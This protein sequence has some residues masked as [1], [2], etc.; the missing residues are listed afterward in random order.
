MRKIISIS[1]LALLCSLSLWANETPV[2]S[3]DSVSVDTV[4]NPDP[5]WYVA[6]LTRDSLR[7]GKRALVAATSCAI[8]SVHIFNEDS[9]LTGVTVYEYGDTTRTLTWTINSDGSRVGLSKE[10]SGTNGDITFSASYEWDATANNWKGTAKEEHTFAG[11]K[12]TVRTSYDWQNGAW[13]AKTQYTWGYDASGRE[14]EYTTYVRNTAGSLVYSKQRLREY[15]AAGRMVQEIQ[16]TAHNGTA[17]SAG[18]KRIYDYDG[19]NI[20]LNEYYSTYT[21]GTWVGSSKEI[22]T[23]TAGKKTYYEK[24]TWSNGAWVG[25]S[26]EIWVFNGPSSKQ[27]LHETYSWTNGDWAVTA[28]ENSGYDANGNNTLIENYT[29]TNGVQKGSKK[30]ENTFSGSTKVETVTYKWTNDAWVKNVK[31]VNN[32]VSSPAESCRYSWNG[33]EW[34]GSGNRTLTTNNSS[35]KP[36]EVITQTWSSETNSWV[37]YTRATT[38]YTGSKTTQEATY[39]WQNDAWVGTSRSDWHYNAKG[40]ND[41]IKTYTNNGTEWIYSD[42]TAKTYNA[43]GTEI[44][45]HKAQWNGEKWVMTSMTRTDILDHTID[46]VRQTLNASWRC[47][48][49]SVWIG[50]Q[51]DTAVFSATGKQIYA[52]K[53]TSWANNDW[54][55]SYKQTLVYDEADRLLLNERYNWSAN[56]WKGSFRYEYGYDEQGRQTYSATYN[57]WSSTTN[58]WVGTTMTETVFNEMGQTAEKKLYNWNN[59]WTAFNR[60]LYTYDAEGHLIDQIVQSNSNNGW[61]NALRYEKGYHNNILVVSNDYTWINNAWCITSKNEKTYDEDSDA[62][63]RR[64]IIGKWNNSTGAAISFADNR[65]FYDCDQHLYT[66]RFLNENGAILESKQVQNGTMPAFSGE[67]PTKEA[68]AENTYTFTGW[69]KAIAEVSGDATYTAVFSATKRQYTITWLNEDGTEI[70]HETLEYGLTPAH[71]D[72]YKESTAEYTYTFTGWDKEITPVIG[73]A[74]YKAVFSATKRQYTI[75]WLNE[76]GTEIDHE[77][78]E[79]GLTPAHADIYKE[80]TAEYTYTFTGWDKEITPVIGDA[81]YKAAFTTTKRQY[82]IIWLNEDGSELD[83]Q[84]L[85]YGAMPQHADATK[86]STAE[87]TYTFAGWGKEIASVT[88]NE[89]YQATFTATK[90]QYTITWLNEDNS[91]LAQ[92][93]VEYGVMPTAPETPSKESTAEYTYTFVGWDAEPASVTGNAAYTAVFTATKRQYTITWLS[94]DGSMI[95]QTTVEYGAMPQHADPSKESTAEYT[96]TF[97]GWDAEP[98]SVT[99]DATYKATFTATKRQYTITWLSDDG[100]MIDQTTVEYGAM[101]QHADPS[102]EPTAEYTYTFVGWDSDP[103]PVTGAAIYKAVYS[104]NKNS[105]TVTFYFEDGVT[106]LDSQTLEYGETPT[107]TMTPS[108]NAEEHYYYTFIGWSPEITPV[109]GDASYTPVFTKEPKQYTITFNNYNGRQLWTTTVPYGETPEYNGETPTRLRTQQYT[110]TFAGWSPEL[111]AVSGNATYTALFDAIVNQ[112][113]VVFQNEDGTEL[114]RQ[115]VDYGTKPEYQGETPTKEPDE[116]YRYEFAGWTP[117]IAAV[118]GDATYTATYTRHDL[119]EGI[120]NVQSP[121]MEA[122]KVLRNGTFYILRG[123]KTYTLDGVLVE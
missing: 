36:V 122:Q 95:D 29:Y 109:T 79:Y 69:D 94:D 111:T 117:R 55:P 48:A 116:N 98:A 84:T 27:T 108:K 26:K 38:E 93:T 101:P 82:T 65:Y 67:T 73:D 115:L 44:M 2:S 12:E 54:I 49:D 62:K 59:G 118:Y 89:T 76:D 56:K 5:E 75:T 72:I 114:D 91:Q 4:L 7:A 99:G 10:E 90:R 37:N 78:L 63:L 74:T 19:S 87:Y 120:D 60:Y 17:W 6:P 100:S 102:K 3:I 23:Y 46:G 33:T 57:S 61:Q 8:D 39:A 31:T 43:A 83:R 80:S 20:I 21:N 88:G 13:S 52:A 113:T 32:K 45:T 30:E 47:G 110:Y 9:V 85:E 50:V 15:N 24:N 22:W 105:Y 86:E 119:H 41:T 71:A 96:Y 25:S 14:I 92:T 11:G 106:V 112:Y 70:S 1:L 121:C 107:T 34:V 123:G 103:A 66:I 104:S 97:V 35:N 40:Q 51:K 68:T 81:T 77:T 18:T 53:Y 16:Y 58:N 42:R 64:E 28:Q